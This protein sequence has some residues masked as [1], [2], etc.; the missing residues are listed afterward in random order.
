MFMCLRCVCVCVLVWGTYACICLFL[1]FV[2]VPTFQKNNK[3]AKKKKSEKKKLPRVFHFL[4][5][6]NC[7]N[8][9]LKASKNF[10]DIFFYIVSQKLSHFDTLAHTSNSKPTLHMQHKICCI[11][12]Y[13]TYVYM[14]ICHV[15][16]TLNI[17]VILCVYFL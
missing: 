14:C 13:V 1:L 17:C 3:C 15:Y 5:L 6:S 10:L 16:V 11:M 4:R 7:H 8:T 12:R 2:F 9:L